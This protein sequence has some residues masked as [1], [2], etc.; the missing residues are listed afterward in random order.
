MKQKL[1]V[2][3]ATVQELVRQHYKWIRQFYEPT[4]E[5]YIGLGELYVS[6]PEFTNYY[7]RYHEGLAEYLCKA[8]KVFAENNL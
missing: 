2:T 5:I 4:K 8:M 1:K 7:D 6:H 3:D